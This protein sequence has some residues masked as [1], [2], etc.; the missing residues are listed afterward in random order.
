MQTYRETDKSE[1]SHRNC[2][3]IFILSIVRIKGSQQNYSVGKIVKMP[4]PVALTTRPRTLMV[5]M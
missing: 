2:R 1:G 5:E 4:G 3:V